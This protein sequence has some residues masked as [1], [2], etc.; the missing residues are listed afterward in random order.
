MD[1]VQTKTQETEFSELVRRFRPDSLEPYNNKDLANKDYKWRIKNR[2]VFAWTIMGIL[3]FQNFLIY[4]LI[5]LAFFTRQ[6][7]SL[8]LI[9]GVLLSGTLVETYFTLN[10]VVKWLFNDIDYKAMKDF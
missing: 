5:Y 1:D 7:A 3:I 10:H 9:L 8:Q 6:L 2:G 4:V